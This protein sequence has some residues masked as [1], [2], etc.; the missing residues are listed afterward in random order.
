MRINSIKQLLAYIIS[1]PKS[2]YVC[3][4]L[5]PINQAYKLPIIVNYRCKLLDLSGECNIA[6][7]GYFGAF[8]FG[9]GNISEIDSG[10]QVPILK[11]SGTISVTPPIRFGPCSRLINEKN[12]RLVIG[13][14]FMNSAKITI[15]NCGI[16]TIGDEFLS[17]WD[18][19][20]CD[21][22]YHPIQNISTNEILRPEGLITI[23]NHV[24]MCARSVIFKG[25]EIPDGCIIASCSLINKKIETN[26]TLLAGM[27]ACP[28]KENVM[29][30]L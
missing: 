24:W 15:S 8:T 5:L 16:I 6:G 25:A 14:R 21:S 3:F 4:R 17:S 28:K 29:Y 10:D 12:A 13:K 9:F 7:G 27:P 2:I 11:I 19:W 1:L 23:G 18:T 22:N 30:I 26:N 20:I